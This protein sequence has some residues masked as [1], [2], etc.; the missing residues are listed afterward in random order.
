[1]TDTEVMWRCSVCGKWSPAKRKPTRHKV[2]ALLPLDEYP[3]SRIAEDFDYNSMCL[4]FN[5]HWDSGVDEF[6][7]GSSCE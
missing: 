3:P 7:A 6:I 1:M 2:P 5:T 4:V